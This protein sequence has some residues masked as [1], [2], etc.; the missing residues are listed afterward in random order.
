MTQDSAE[1]R[2]R[3]PALTFTR[4]ARRV[5]IIDVTIELLADH[6]YSGVSLSQIADRAGVTKPTVLY[7]FTDKSNLVSSVYRHV[8]DAVVESVGG[9][10]EAAEVE[11]RPAAYV[12]SLVAHFVRYPSHARV[13]I[14]A[15]IHGGER[16][17]SSARWKPVADLLAAARKSRGATDEVEL[18]TAALI[19]GGAIDAV[20]AE[21]VEDPKF[22]AV[23]ASEEIVEL[24]EARYL[25]G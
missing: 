8:L 6:G 25:A 11:E 1:A 15:L 22:D 10:V 23:A 20:V 16:A 7:H 4:R 24:I 18:R 12:R 14:E 9:A 3:E 2:S 21:A 13:S 5:Q 19:I 17:E